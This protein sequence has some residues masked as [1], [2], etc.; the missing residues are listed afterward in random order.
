MSTKTFIYLM[1]AW[2]ALWFWVGI[3]GW[4]LLTQ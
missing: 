3:V 2:F 1:V 4:R